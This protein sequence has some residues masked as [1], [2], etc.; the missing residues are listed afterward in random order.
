MTG[1][2]SAITACLLAAAALSWSGG[3]RDLAAQQPHWLGFRGD[4]G[5][6]VPRGNAAELFQGNIRGEFSLLFQPRPFPPFYFGFGMSWT[7]F[8]IESAYLHSCEYDTVPAPTECEPWNS[9][10][11]QFFVGA[12]LQKLVQLPLFLEA[13]LI[14]RRLRPADYQYWPINANQ[15]VRKTPYPEHR[16]MGLEGAAGFQL[17]LTASTRMDLA[18]RIGQFKPA[19]VVFQNPFARLPALTGGWTVGLQLGLVWFP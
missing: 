5:A 16:G 9:V 13:R 11:L 15:Y 14:E 4:M 10:G 8:H 1:Y 6:E 3:M 7:T 12:Y 18:A 19:G 2:R 17:P